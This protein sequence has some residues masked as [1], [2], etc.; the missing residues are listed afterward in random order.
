MMTHRRRATLA[1][2]LRPGLHLGR[3]VVIDCETIDLPGAFGEV[4]VV[5]TKGTVRV[6]SVQSMGAVVE[7]EGKHLP[8]SNQ[9]CNSHSS[10]DNAAKRFQSRWVCRQV[11]QVR[12][13][14]NDRNDQR[15]VD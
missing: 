3:A 13:D 7:I 15:C 5:D 14:R 8:D 10:S 1:P 11:A 6:I 9:C 2:P 12:S 4:G